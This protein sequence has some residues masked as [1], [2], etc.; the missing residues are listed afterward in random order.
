MR[1]VFSDYFRYEFGQTVCLGCPRA[2][3]S[4]ASSSPPKWCEPPPP[5]CSKSR[6]LFAIAICVTWGKKNT[7]KHFGRDGVQDKQEPSLG[8][9]GPLPGTNRHPSLGQTGRFLFNYSKITILSP[10]SLGR[11]GV[12]PWAD[13]PA[14]V[15]RKMFMCFLFIGVFRPNVIRIA[16]RRS[17]AIWDSANLLREA[18]CYYL[19]YSKSALR[20]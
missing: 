20:F 13:C 3:H 1:T 7:N 15:V 10:L 9:T 12:C 14:R 18:Q 2:L 8:Q 11:A 16:N 4:G 5:K 17:L 6:D 19:L